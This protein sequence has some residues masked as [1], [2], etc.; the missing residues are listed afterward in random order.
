[1][2]VQ[3]E[4]YNVVE[5]AELNK[6]GNRITYGGEEN[7]LGRHGINHWLMVVAGRLFYVL[8][9]KYFCCYLNAEEN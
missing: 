7:D 9:F 4:H 1:M 6:M 3:L 5:V 2:L 8:N